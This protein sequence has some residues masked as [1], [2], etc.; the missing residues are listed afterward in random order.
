MYKKILVPLDG[1]MRAEKILP[2]IKM[3]AECMK[4]KV[5]LLRVYRIDYDESDMVGHDPSFCEAIEA[6]CKEN[7]EAY[8]HQ[9]QE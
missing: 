5:V 1:S 2:P 4:A 8:L 3:L 6:R 7:A 9:V